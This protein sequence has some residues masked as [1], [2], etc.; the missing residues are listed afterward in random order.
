VADHGAD[1]LVSEDERAKWI[2]K[3]LVDNMQVGPADGAGV[4]ID[5]DLARAGRR[6]RQIR[7]SKGM[8]GCVEE[9]R[10]HAGKLLGH[11]AGPGEI[12]GELGAR[13][14]AASITRSCGL[15]REIGHSRH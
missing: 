14:L 10:A 2:G 12:I 5:E 11:D 9:H 4:N 8:P 1:D 15:S 6:G 7:E 13:A 3:L